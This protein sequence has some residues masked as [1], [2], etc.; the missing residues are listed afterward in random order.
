L[1]DLLPED[2]VQAILRRLFGPSWQ[3]QLKRMPKLEPVAPNPRLTKEYL[4]PTWGLEKAVN[5]LEGRI[6]SERFEAE[7]HGIL[8]GVK[9]CPP[10]KT[11][12]QLR[13]KK[14]GRPT[15]YDRPMTWAERQRRRRGKSVFQARKRGLG[16][17]LPDYPSSGFDLGAYRRL[18]PWQ[19]IRI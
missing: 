4:G 9:Y 16:G 5:R 15:K 3:L 19:Q 8:G 18:P 13:P 1:F 6:L 17:I 2:Q 14:I 10:E 12:A 11:A 7:P